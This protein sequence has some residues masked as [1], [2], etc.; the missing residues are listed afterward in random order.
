MQ[1]LLKDQTGLVIF[2][3]S[4]KVE[5][6]RQFKPVFEAYAANNRN[7]QILF[8]A[9][10]VYEQNEIGQAFKIKTIPHLKFMNK[11]KVVC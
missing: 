2:F 4:P 1:K 8:C 7:S 10:N 11:D 6:S 3:F 5:P 9:V